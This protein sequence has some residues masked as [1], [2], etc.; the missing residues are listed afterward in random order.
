MACF[1]Q[2]LPTSVIPGGHLPFPSTP[3]RHTSPFHVICGGQQRAVLEATSSERSLPVGQLADS[4]STHFLVTGSSS[5]A[6]GQAGLAVVVH[7]P[8]VGWNVLP[9]GQEGLMSDTHTP[10]LTRLPSSHS[11]P[12]T[13]IHTFNVLWYSVP[14]GQTGGRSL[15]QCPSWKANPSGHWGFLTLTHV[16]PL[17]V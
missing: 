3:I 5:E 16:L 11:G 12:E 15:T 8:L 1:W 17:N 4:D 6:G 7:F 14:P 9:S 2:N 13:E 10:S